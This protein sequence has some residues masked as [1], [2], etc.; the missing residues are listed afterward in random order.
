M[1]ETTALGAAVAAG[2]AVG[3]W[4]NFEELANINV[5]GRT[6]FK[7]QMPSE[8]SSKMFSRW[9]RAVVMSKGWAE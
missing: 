7:P 4:K 9:N 8:E 1:R 2:F 5:H 6:V 3:V